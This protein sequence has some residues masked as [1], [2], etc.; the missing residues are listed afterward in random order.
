[1]FTGRV[2]GYEVNE[3][4]KTERYAISKLNLT[5]LSEKYTKALVETARNTN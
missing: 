4:V 1:M 2:N 3:R 5:F